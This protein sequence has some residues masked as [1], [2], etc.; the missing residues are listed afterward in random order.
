MKSRM[1][2]VAW[3]EIPVLNMDRAIRFYETV[4]DCVLSRHIMGD[5]EMAW[6]PH[7]DNSPGA[8]GTLI[9]SGDHYTPSHK[10]TLVYFS[11]EDV[12]VELGRVED[13]GGLVL[14]L[15]TQITPE[16]GYMGLFEDS[17]GN[18]IAIHSLN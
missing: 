2:S 14:Q 1:V 12:S 6:F 15:K 11:S 7:N 10:G 18:R 3:F 16:I 4:F 8:G 13:A 9:T 5:T 17:E